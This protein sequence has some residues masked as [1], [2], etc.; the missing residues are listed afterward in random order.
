LVHA[1]LSLSGLSQVLYLLMKRL[2]VETAVDTQCGHDASRIGGPFRWLRWCGARCRGVAPAAGMQHRRKLC[3]TPTCQYLIHSDPEFGGYCC[4]RCH[5]QHAAN[6]TGHIHGKCC[7]R[8]LGDSILERASPDPP[9]MLHAVASDVL[10]MREGTLGERRVAEDGWAYSLDEFQQWYRNECASRWDCAGRLAKTAVPPSGLVVSHIGESI[11]GKALQEIQPFLAGSGEL[12]IGWSFRR[13]NY[14]D[15]SCESTTSP[16]AAALGDFPC[17]RLL[18]VE[19]MHALGSMGQLDERLNVICRLYQENGITM[20]CDK[21][22]W[23][24]E[25]VYGCVLKNSSNRALEFH[26]IIAGS[27]C[28]RRCYV[29]DEEAGTCFCQSGPARFAWKHGVAP[30]THGERV[31][32][33]WRWLKPEVK[34]VAALSAV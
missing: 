4:K 2:F 11:V 23:F 10:A 13:A 21:K 32:V 8:R 17:V 15:D 26:K 16:E 27:D 24:E 14:D 28:A 33:T 6:L 7:Q 9:R 22:D 5:A 3:A 30:L 1:V 18:M 12:E 31:S 34:L 29:V 20:H 25:D 19:V